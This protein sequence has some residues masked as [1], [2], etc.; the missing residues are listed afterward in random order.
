MRP[1]QGCQRAIQAVHLGPVEVL[2]ASCAAEGERHPA[3]R[4][5]PGRESAAAADDT[6]NAALLHERHRRR[7]PRA[8]REA[9]DVEPPFVDGETLERVTHHRQPGAHG[10]H[11]RTIPRDVGGHE[12][13]SK[14]LGRFPEAFERPQSPRGGIER[15]EGRPL[16]SG[17]V[18]R[19]QV[20]GVALIRVGPG[21][22]GGDDCSRA[23]RL[24]ALAG[25]A[26]VAEQEG[27]QRR[28][29]RHGETMPGGGDSSHAGIIARTARHS[30]GSTLRL[31]MKLALAVKHA[32]LVLVVARTG[33]GRRRDGLLGSGDVLG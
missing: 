31:P 17:V 26:R 11:H 9:R 21:H 12:D 4:L 20:E 16:R 8:A 27:Q 10:R 13:V 23:N 19:R 33:H 1:A 25:G 7:D 22:D 29:G 30:A 18:G 15:V 32:H 24:D 14:L 5:L 28:R 3:T 2:V 6:G